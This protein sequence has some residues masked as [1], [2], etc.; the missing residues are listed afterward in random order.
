MTRRED[1]TDPE[2]LG[3]AVELAWIGIAILIA[4]TVVIAIYGGDRG[5]NTASNG[6]AVNS[7]ETT[8]STGVR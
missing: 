2:K 7:R 4:L 8:G 5:S 1:D 3:S 6:P